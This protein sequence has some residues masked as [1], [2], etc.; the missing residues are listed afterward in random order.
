MLET[1]ASCLLKQH[2]S[3]MCPHSTW[4][5]LCLGKDNRLLNFKNFNFFK[6]K[7]TSNMDLTTTK[8]ITIVSKLEN[9]GL[10]NWPRI[11]LDSFH[12]SIRKLFFKI[13]HLNEN[14]S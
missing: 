10:N 8:K 9:Q 12:R 2:H 5:L 3:Q 7:K 11:S 4:G 1:F 13:T 14:A 6:M